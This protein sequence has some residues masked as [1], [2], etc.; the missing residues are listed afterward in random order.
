MSV[1]ILVVQDHSGRG[2]KNRQ[3]MMEAPRMYA[4]SFHSRRSGCENSFTITSEHPIY[5]KVPAAKLV[6]TIST[7]V[8]VLR[9]SMPRVMPIGEEM[10]NMRIRHLHSFM[11][12]G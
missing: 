11:L 7:K 4:S 6:K 3:M 12:S 8:S 9:I 1:L 5:T 2:T 10:A